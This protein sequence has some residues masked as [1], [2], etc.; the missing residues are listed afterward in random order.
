MGNQPQ[1]AAAK[2]AG[3]GFGNKYQ[4]GSRLAEW[5]LLSMYSIYWLMQAGLAYSFVLLA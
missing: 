5:E 4:M 2:P 1:L 3:G